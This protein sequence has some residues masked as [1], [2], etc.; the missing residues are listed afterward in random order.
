METLDEDDSN[1]I[2]YNEFGAFAMQKEDGLCTKDD[3]SCTESDGF[4]TEN[5]G[6]C[7]NK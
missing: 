7:T 4:C 1:E 2:E 5:A 6:F 3:G